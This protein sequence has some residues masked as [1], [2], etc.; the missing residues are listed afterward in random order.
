VTA[1]NSASALSSAAA[2]CRVRSASAV[3]VI[4]SR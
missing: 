4:G 3:A 2:S 1:A